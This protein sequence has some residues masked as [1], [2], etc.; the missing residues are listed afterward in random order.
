MSDTA[1][2]F[3]AGGEREMWEIKAVE[4]LVA[5]EREASDS[6][7]LIAEGELEASDTMLAELVVAEGREG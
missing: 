1:A 5:G 2:E 4:S 6:M 3:V 7:R